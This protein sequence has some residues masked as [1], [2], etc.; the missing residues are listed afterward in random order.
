MSKNRLL[1]VAKTCEYLGV[2][3]HTLRRWRRMGEGPAYVKIASNV[4]SYRESDLDAWVA[5]RRVQIVGGA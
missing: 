5:K 1:S 3:I 2:S 4:I